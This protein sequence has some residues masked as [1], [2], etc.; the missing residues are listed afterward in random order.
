MK[1]LEA[2]LHDNVYPIKGFNKRNNDHS[3][4]ISQTVIK[5]DVG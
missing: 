2:L 5:D 1:I 3:N 4:N